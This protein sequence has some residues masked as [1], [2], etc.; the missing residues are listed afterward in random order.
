MPANA[1]SAIYVLL[2]VLAA[3]VVGILLGLVFGHVW[4]G[5]AAALAVYLGWQ[6][7]LL[8][9][10]D[11]W[12]RN[13]RVADPPDVATGLWG[14]VVT[15]VVRLHRRKRFHKDR[16]MRV[17]RELRRS[18]AAMPDGVVVLNNDNEIVWFN[19]K[20]SEFLGLTR[21]VD[22]GLRIDNLVRHPDF[23]RYLKSGQY[24]LPVVVR[25]DPGADRYLA[26]QLV[27]YG[28]DQRLLMIRD[29]SRQVRLELMRKDFVANASHE[30]RSPLTVISGYLETLAD[31]PAVPGELAEPLAEMRRQSVRMTQIIEDLLV[32]SR[33]EAT[34]GQLVGDTVDVGGMLAMLRR[35]VL[36]RPIHPAKVELKIESGVRLIGEETMLHSAF[37]NLVDNAAKYTPAT[38]SVTLRWWDD[39]R[40]AHFS[41]SD[42]GPGIASEHIPRLTERFYRVDAG[43]SRVTGGSGLGLAI[44]K[45]VLQRHSAELEVQST[46][47]KG[48]TFT[49]H[50]PLSR[51]EQPVT[52][53][54]SG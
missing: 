6:L 25:P 15:Q 45:H 47:G 54:A 36:A 51:V 50:F 2:R 27:R 26:F 8:V 21:K 18:T 4:A 22:H 32:L 13:R 38:G 3:I 29:V 28:E 10:L 52:Q 30:L 43:R 34:D 42:T 23:T 39:A 37:M 24:A 49:C 7:W 16:V 11:N 40:G 35:D 33:L 20:A 44:V 1:T 14:D 17:L 53:V 5:V 31:D 41:V 12:L 48:S 9:R 19:H 46:E